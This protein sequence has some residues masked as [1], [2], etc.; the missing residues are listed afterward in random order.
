[1][2][3]ALGW[4]GGKDAT[5]ALDRAVRQGLDV[6]YLF[7]IHEGT[8]GLVRFHGVRRE[9]IARQ[10]EALGLE[11]LEGRTD[12][13]GF[14]AELLR[15]LD[16]LRLRGVEA[17]LFGNIHLADV[18]GWYE[19]R[20]TGLGFRHVEPLWGTPPADAA[21]ELVARGYRARVVSVNLEIGR[22]EWLGRNFDA[23]LLEE[24]R[25]T[26]GVDA[27]GER[28]EY[29]TFVFDGPLFRHPVAHETGVVFEREGHRIQ[30]LV[31][32]GGESDG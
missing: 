27:A 2:R 20:T 30:D 13:A 1:M 3:C 26:E 15:I 29:H 25:R 9:L 5:L 4:S 12:P 28:G 31:P 8:S 23:A 6:R 18:R 19:E 11:L 7:N 14:E 22:A 24:L 32:S 21:A 17:I 16:A 10:A